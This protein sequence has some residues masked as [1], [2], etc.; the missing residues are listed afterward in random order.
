MERSISTVNN[1]KNKLSKQQIDSIDKIVQACHVKNAKNEKR[2]ALI[3]EYLN[4]E[5]RFTVTFGEWLTSHGYDGTKYFQPIAFVKQHDLY[6]TNDKENKEIGYADS[7]KYVKQLGILIPDES[8]LS[9]VDEKSYHNI[10]SS[11]ENSEYN[12]KFGSKSEDSFNEDFFA[13]G[14]EDILNF[15]GKDV[16]GEFDMEEM[17]HFILNENDIVNDFRDGVINIRQEMANADASYSNATGS[18]SAYD[19]S[20]DRSCWIRF[21]F[22]KD[23]RETCQKNKDIRKKEE[24]EQKEQEKAT[25][26]NERNEFRNDKKNCKD[27][28]KKG[29]ISYS[30]YRKCV[31]GE[32][33]EKRNAIKENGGGNF[34]G[35]ASNSVNRF[36]PVTASTRAGAL[37]LIKANFLKLATKLVPAVTN[38]RSILSKFKPTAI[39]NS[40]KAYSKVLKAWK[41]MGG[42]KD[43][44]DDAITKGWNKKEEK[45]SNRSSFDGSDEEYSNIGGSESGFM[46]LAIAFLGALSTVVNAIVGRQKDM[47]SSSANLDVGAENINE[48]L[49]KEAIENGDAPIINSDGEFIDPLTGEKIDPKTGN[50]IDDKIIGLPKWAFYT[51][52]SVVAVGVIA[53]II[54]LAKK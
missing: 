7:L 25:R 18:S 10:I 51:G 6:A 47:M 5:D 49:A 30:D 8:I 27:R 9:N 11:I 2:L 26:K 39:E 38:D 48:D 29:E 43:G 50:V 1:G 16:D 54:K 33:I 32:R 45:I 42:S 13:L 19:D 36:N 22:D 3:D 14:T 12:K 20:N 37:T 31:K 28:Y 4:D 35:R 24:K 40:K 15:S 52:V 44:L 17:K 46:A 53:V 23:K 34:F 21:P 41:A